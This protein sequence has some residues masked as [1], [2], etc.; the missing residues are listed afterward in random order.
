VAAGLA[1]YSIYLVHE[2]IAAVIETVGATRVPTA[3]LLV[4]TIVACLAAG[5]AFWWAVER[6]FHG[7][8]RSRALSLRLRIRISNYM[9]IAQVPERLRLEPERLQLR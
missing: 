4:A 3:A 5:F 1:S 9:R 7:T 6:A 2:P 8:A